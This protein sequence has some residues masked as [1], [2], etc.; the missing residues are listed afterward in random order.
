VKATD[1]TWTVDNPNVASVDENGRVTAV[2]KGDTVVRA[3]FGDQTA[4]CVVRV[5]YTPQP[6]QEAKYKIS[7]TD[8]TLY[9]GDS[10][11]STFRIELSDRETGAAIPAEWTASDEGYVTIDGKIVSAVKATSD[12]SKKYITLTATVEGETYTCIVRIAEKED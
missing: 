9:L 2:G 11:S 6:A 8:V 7:H 4:E 10:S 1:I 3:T 5:S 12:L